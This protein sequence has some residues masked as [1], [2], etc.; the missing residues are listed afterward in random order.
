MNFKAFT[1]YALFICFAF[2]FSNQQIYCASKS[3]ES[4]DLDSAIKHNYK[5]YSERK[6]NNYLALLNQMQTWTFS[7]TIKSVTDANNIAVK[8]KDREVSVRFFQN[9]AQYYKK[10]DYVSIN[11]I[12]YRENANKVISAVGTSIEKTNTEVNV[13]SNAKATQSLGPLANDNNIVSIGKISKTP[14]LMGRNCVLSGKVTKIINSDG[15]IIKYGDRDIMLSLR[16]REGTRLKVGDNVIVS[17]FLYKEDRN[18]IILAS[19]NSIK[20]Q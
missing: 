12:P 1:K 4:I 7:G 18:G 11:S 2:I 10:G 5:I 20:K 8:T 3:D 6:D 17:C 13:V 16:K 19:V 15:I 14:L 9:N